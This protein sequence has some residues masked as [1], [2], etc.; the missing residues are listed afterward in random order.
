[1]K[2][3]FTVSLLIV[4]CFVAHAQIISGS[5]GYRINSYVINR[6]EYKNNYSDM[7]I[8]YPGN[9]TVIIRVYDR[10]SSSYDEYHFTEDKGSFG[11]SFGALGGNRTAYEFTGT[12]SAGSSNQTRIYGSASRTGGNDTFTPTSPTTVYMTF[13]FNGSS[14]EITLEFGR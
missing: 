2:K 7:G 9:G 14:N 5:R 1:M 6:S 8:F 4:S 11:R 3:L 13:Q 12:L 10:N